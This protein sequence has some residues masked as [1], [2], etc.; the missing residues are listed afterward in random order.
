MLLITLQFK[1]NLYE[2]VSGVLCKVLIVCI[3]LSLFAD[4][5]LSAGVLLIVCDIVEYYYIQYVKA[6][7]LYC[8]LCLRV[9]YY[10]LANSQHSFCA[11]ILKRIVL[12]A[13][14]S[15]CHMLCICWYSM[16]SSRLFAILYKKHL[17]CMFLCAFSIYVS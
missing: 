4:T 5:S 15:L 9:L 8:P 14:L 6:L 13:S 16:W 12:G 7:R 1:L 11:L 10:Q 2:R 17:S 3:L